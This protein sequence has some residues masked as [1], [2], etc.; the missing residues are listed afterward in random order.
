[1]EST[2]KNYLDTSMKKIVDDFTNIED[3]HCEND[4]S[5]TMKEINAMKVKTQN[6]ISMLGKQAKTLG[7]DKELISLTDHGPSSSSTSKKS[8]KNTKK[9]NCNLTQ[10]PKITTREEGKR[11]S[12]KPS[13]LNDYSS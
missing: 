7:V 10:T 1:M 12:H 6:I 5:E 3:H 4:C 13:Y 2:A 9:V 8:K 11:Y